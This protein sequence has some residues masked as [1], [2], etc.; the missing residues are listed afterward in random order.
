MTILL[1]L[2]LYIN[3]WFGGRGFLTEIVSMSAP[4]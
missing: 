3:F 1:L 4:Q 2:K